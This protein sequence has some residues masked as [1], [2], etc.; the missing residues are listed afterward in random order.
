ME[1]IRV[2]GVDIP[3]DVYQ[4]MLD[5]DLDILK[6]DTVGSSPGIQTPH[7]LFQNQN[8]A[9]LFSR[10]GAEPDAY[11]AMV[12]PTGGQLLSDL[13]GGTSNII[14]PEYDIITGVKAGKGSNAVNFCSPGPKAGEAKLCTQRAQFGEIKMDLDQVNLMKT[15]GRINRADMDVRIINNPALFPLAPDVLRRANNPNTTLGLSLMRTAVH[16]QRVLLRVLFHGS[17]SNTGSNAELGFIKEFDG[18]DQKIKTGHRDLETND[19]CEAADS[20]I[21]NWGNADIAASVGGATIVDTIAGIVYYLMALAEDSNMSP[22]TWKMAMHRD[23]FWRLT[24]LWPC[25]YLTNGCT[26]SS[27]AGQSL[28][29]DAPMQVQMRDEMR[30]GKF[31]W[32][33]GIKFPVE[34]LS[35][36]E[37]TTLGQ[38]FSSPIYF[39]PI[40]ALG[41][42]VT[43]LEGFDLNNADI[44]EFL[45]FYPN[46]PITIMNS[47]LYMMGSRVTDACVEGWLASELRLVMRTPWLAARIENI[48]YAL[49]G[50]IYTRDAFPGGAYHKNGGRYYSAP[51]TYAN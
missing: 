35:A 50:K 44:Q 1:T 22:V 41:G 47:G 12:M 3:L 24:A 15:G 18:F 40:T 19:T 46:L 38:G 26:V 39:I 51:P 27:S 23:L 31:L 7:G 29:V 10:P 36:I 9:G 16:L 48:N 30:N 20:L 34:P 5:A 13:Y 4:K 28:N 43:K 17:L 14:N 49:P 37:Q 33:N 32:V 21:V 6:H 25:S 8:V 2:K 42:Q 45:G 11:S